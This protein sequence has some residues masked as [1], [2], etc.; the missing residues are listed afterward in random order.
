[1]AIIQKV[2]YISVFLRANHVCHHTILFL[3]LGNFIIKILRTSYEAILFHTVHIGPWL[4][5]RTLLLYQL[6]SI[7]W[8][9]KGIILWF[10]IFGLAGFAGATTIKNIV[11]FLVQATSRDYFFCFF[12]SRRNSLKVNVE[13]LEIWNKILFEYMQ[14]LLL[15]EEF[16]VLHL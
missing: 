4:H 15:D 7:I 6:I 13:L 10:L 2:L 8:K 14:N 16:V 12:D 11:K 5:L 9:Q 3:M 1:M